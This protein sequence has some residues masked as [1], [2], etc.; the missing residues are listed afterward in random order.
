MDI[1]DYDWRTLRGE[2]IKFLT[3]GSVE[4]A[5]SFLKSN[6]ISYIY[7]VKPLMGLVREDQTLIKKIYTNSEIDIFKVN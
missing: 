1:T 7:W 2:L 4:D 5:R 3:T 6:N